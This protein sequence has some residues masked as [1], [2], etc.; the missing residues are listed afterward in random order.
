MSWLQVE[1]QAIELAPYVAR[2]S[3][4]QEDAVLGGL[5]RLWRYAFS[6]KKAVLGALEVRG[7]FAVE[8]GVDVLPALVEYDFLEQLETGLRVRG[9]ERY[10]RVSEG[11]SKGGKA[12]AG[13]LK[14]GPSP[15]SSP[16]AAGTKPELEQQSPSR[17]LAGVEA[18]GGSR[19]L[20]GCSRDQAGAPSRL[21]PGPTSNIEHRDDRG[22]MS[23]PRS[24]NVRDLA[25]DKNPQGV[26]GYPLYR[27]V[28]EFIAWAKTV[29]PPSLGDPGPMVRDWAVAFFDKY[30]PSSQDGIRAAFMR[31]VVW[32]S[33]SGK[34]VGWGL[35][36]QPQVWQTRWDDARAERGAA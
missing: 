22:S 8:A 21:T 18:G 16:A 32:A 19:L 28:D 12:A 17:V 1:L 13:N 15:G 36:L 5:L 34:R 35:W 29:D 23:S 9:A 11:R 2:A 26:N 31:F 14:R 20:S 24:N 30:Q 4:C 33:S 27:N 25:E 6:A 7:C 10:L 3:G